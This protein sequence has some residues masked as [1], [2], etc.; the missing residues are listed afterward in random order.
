MIVDLPA[1]EGPTRA[2]VSPGLTV[3]EISFSIG[4]SGL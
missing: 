3:N 1:P 4:F 2:S